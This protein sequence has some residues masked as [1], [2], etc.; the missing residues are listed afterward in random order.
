MHDL[1]TS[2]FTILPDALPAP[3]LTQLT[4]AYDAAV[5]NAPPDNIRIGSTTVRV[6]GLAD[7]PDFDDVATYEPI[8]EACRHLIAKPFK[9]SSLLARTVMPGAAAQPLHADVQPGEDG[10]PLLGFVVM[11]DDFTRDNGA[12]RFLVGEEEVVACGRAGSIIVYNGSTMHGHS[13]NRTET[14]RRSIQG[15]YVPL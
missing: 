2:G 8:L 9:L 14:P 10:Y 7:S 5:R 15:A 4:A 3:R 11:I 1:L 13:A 12:T 6:H